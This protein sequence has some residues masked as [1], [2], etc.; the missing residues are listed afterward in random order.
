MGLMSISL[1]VH[2]LWT[3]SKLNELIVFHHH[4]SIATH[5][6]TPDGQQGTQ[7]IPRQPTLAA[8]PAYLQAVMRLIQTCHS[9]LDQVIRSGQS[10]YLNAPT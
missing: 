8:R 2:Y 6:G 4:M 7:F 3:W 10:N 1:R 5:E 9:I